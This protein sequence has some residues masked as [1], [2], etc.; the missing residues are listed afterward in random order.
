MSNIWNN[1]LPQ[2][3][4][5]FLC[6]KRNNRPRLLFEENTVPSLPFRTPLTQARGDAYSGLE[7]WRLLDYYTIVG[8]HSAVMVCSHSVFGSLVSV[9]AVVSQSSLGP[10]SKPGQIGKMSASEGLGRG[11]TADHPFPFPDY[12]SA[13]F[14]RKFSFWPTPIF[15][16]FS[17]LCGAW[18][19]AS[20]SRLRVLQSIKIG[21]N[22]VIFIDW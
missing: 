20:S 14:A 10:G 13:R 4:A 6:E 2:I 17:P 15:F 19:Q 8:Y 12:L 9:S 1:R 16:S 18:S 22:Q 11:Q 3:I 5:P 7:R 21:S